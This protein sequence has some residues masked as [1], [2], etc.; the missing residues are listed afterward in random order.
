MRVND[1]LSSSEAYGHLHTKWEEKCGD[2][3]YQGLHYVKVGHVNRIAQHVE[4]T[5]DVCRLIAPC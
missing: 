4:V 2:R 5:R 1:L 3:D